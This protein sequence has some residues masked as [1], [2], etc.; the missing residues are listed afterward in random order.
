MTESG[1]F[2]PKNCDKLC[3]R[4]RTA[5]GERVMA[6]LGVVR[7]AWADKPHAGSAW[8]HRHRLLLHRTPAAAGLG[9]PWADL[10][11]TLATEEGPGFGARHRAEEPVPSAWGGLGPQR[12]LL[13][14]DNRG[15]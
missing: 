12:S 14:I 15:Q 1:Y 4:S 7:S 2:A 11:M 13:E 10:A 8:L 9:F 6:L 3:P 5:A